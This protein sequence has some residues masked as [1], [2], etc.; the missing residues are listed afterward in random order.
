MKV[1]CTQ[2]NLKRGLGITSRVSNGSTTLPVLNNVLIK[3]DQGGL[4]L[5]STN[6]EMGVN[7]WIRCKVDEQGGISVP[8]KT[9]VDLINNLP[10]DNVTLTTENNHLLIETSNYQTKIKGLAPDEFPLIPQIEEQNPIEVKSKELKTA[11]SQTAFAAAYSETQPEISGILFNFEEGLLKMAATD[12]YRLA[13][14]A[15]TIKNSVVKSLIIPN[16]AVQELAKIL[17]NGDSDVAQIFFS[18][19]Q[20]M[21]KTEETELT[22]RLIDGQYPDYKQIVPQ[23]FNTEI[24]L[25]AD[26]LSTA[27]RTAGIFT[28]TGNNV[29]LE[30]EEPDKLTISSSSG[31]LGES[32]LNIPCK[33]TGQSGKI[34]FNHRYILDCLSTI[35]TKNV[36]FQIINENSPALLMSRDLPGYVYLVMPI[37][38]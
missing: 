30:F 20:I 22:S 29:T 2:E 35:G 26:Q 32:K 4:K 7:T 28:Q 3:T 25:A 14:K 8:A 24:D 6:L 17:G 1:I 19:N 21:F 5:S 31:D 12:R 16:K 33:V 10:N 11:I 15:L 9:F 13:E 23:T 37:K 27:M 34:I 38:I 18:Q 36:T